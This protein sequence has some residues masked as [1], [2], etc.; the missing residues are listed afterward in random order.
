MSGFIVAKFKVGDRVRIG[1]KWRGVVVAK[2]KNRN[3]GFKVRTTV[4]HGPMCAD[5]FWV[6]PISLAHMEETK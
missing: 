5:E 4:P 2:S 6:R 3:N 1:R